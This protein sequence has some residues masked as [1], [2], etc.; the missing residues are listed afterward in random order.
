MNE[1]KQE[2]ENHLT[3]IFAVRTTIGREK[4]VQEL[5][6]NRLRTIN[7]VPD[8]KAILISENYRGY[9]FIEAIHQ[10]DVLHICNGVPHVKGKIVGSIPFDSIMGVIKPEKNIFIMEEGD[11]VEVTSGLFQNNKARIIK[12]PKDKE[13]AKE[14]VTV[15]LLD[16][17][18]PITVK[19]HADYLKLFEKK[20][21]VISEYVIEN[22]SEDSSDLIEDA[23][24]VADVLID[25]DKTVK[26]KKTSK[27]K[28]VFSQKEVSTTMDDTF[29]FDEEEKDDEIEELAD[30]KDESYEEHDESKDSEEDED[31]WAKFMM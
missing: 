4:A 16:S 28:A 23:E 2:P 31:D 24:K 9:V 6:F 29:S 11:I 10:R 3:S 8:L 15:R 20:R 26:K 13:G 5:I 7:P 17:D 1:Q 14:E 22:E 25:E 21:Q 12:M 19:I 27:K 30:Q 18:S